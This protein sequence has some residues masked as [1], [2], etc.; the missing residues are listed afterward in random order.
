[1]NAKRL[2]ITTVGTSLIDKMKMPGKLDIRGLQ[3]KPTNVLSDAQDP[4]NSTLSRDIEQAC[5]NITAD[6][7]LGCFVNVNSLVGKAAVRLK[8]LNPDNDR[9]AAPAEI[10]SLWAL[11]ARF[12]KQGQL[13]MSKDKGDRVVLLYSQTPEGVFC[14][15][16]LQIYLSCHSG[17]AHCDWTTDVKRIEGL[18]A[19]GQDAYNNWDKAVKSLATLLREQL[20]RADN[21]KYQVWLNITGGYKGI[22]P[23]SSLLGLLNG[24]PVVYLYETSEG[25]IHLPQIP[26]QLDAE[27]Y[28]LNSHLIHIVLNGGGTPEDVGLPKNLH[29]CIEQSGGSWKPTIWGELLEALSE[30]EGRVG[31]A[32]IMAQNY[33]TNQALRSE[34]LG[35]ARH[36]AEYL[37]VECKTPHMVSHGREHLGRLLEFVDEIFIPILNQEKS[38]SDG[39]RTFTCADLYAF[40]SCVWLHD[41]GHISGR[42]CKYGY[43]KVI[44]TPAVIRDLHHLLGEQRILDEGR[45][46]FAFAGQD[47]V[48]VVAKVSAYHRYAMPM[49]CGDDPYKYEKNYYDV[50]RISITE[51]P[52]VQMCFQHNGEALPVKIR[53]LAALARVVDACDV[54]K[55]RAG[56]PFYQQWR[57]MVRE[58]DIEAE[59]ERLNLYKTDFD[60]IKDLCSSASVVLDRI[61]NDLQARIDFTQTHEVQVHFEKHN[62][63]ERVWW[64]QREEFVDQEG[65][66]HFSIVI[67]QTKLEDA[68]Q[69]R[70]EDKPPATAGLAQTYFKESGNECQRLMKEIKRYLPNSLASS[71]TCKIKA[72]QEEIE[73]F[74]GYLSSKCA[75]DKLSDPEEATYSSLIVRLVAF[76]IVKEYAKVH[77]ILNENKLFLDA[78]ELRWGENRCNPTQISLQAKHGNGKLA[79]G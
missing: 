53:F 25:L 15:R 18:Q 74:V 75:N 23:F 58:Q 79:G 78:I 38:C 52:P 59:Q 76:D 9:Y 19:E 20:K 70:R 71:L 47:S 73:L 39:Q 54:Q 42:L 22:T 43:K 7:A 11:N 27:S 64:Q 16:C 41:I 44:V 4:Q 2:V 49:H 45:S 60:V 62:Q 37:R 32:R 36:V 12:L 31:G 17:L 29:A 14:A 65:N 50:P 69:T 77:A 24:I 56:A 67:Q 51:P 6:T 72:I 1:M 68:R 46:R 55:R 28:A 48:N 40:V 10:A 63:V 35:R 13:G 8:K 61:L 21:E 66:Y 26:L 34:V 5:G 30:R 3:K 33:W 57:Q